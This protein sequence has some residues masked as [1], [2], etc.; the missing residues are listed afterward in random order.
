MIKQEDRI[1]SRYSKIFEVRIRSNQILK[2]KVWICSDRIFS[3][4]EKFESDRIW[5]VSNFLDNLLSTTY[6]IKK[7]PRLFFYIDFCTLSTFIPSPRLL[8]TDT[9][10]VHGRFMVSRNTT[11]SHYGT[12]KI[13]KKSKSHDGFLRSKLDRAKKCYRLVQIV[14]FC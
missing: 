9:T 13:W 4:F 12:S 2:F 8:F 6:L 10:R 7:D 3:I 14:L 11:K 1:Y 5:N